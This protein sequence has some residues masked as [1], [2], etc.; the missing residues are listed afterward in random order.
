[1]AYDVRKVAVK[2]SD[3]VIV[4]PNVVHGWA[5]IP[6][7]VDYLSFRPSQSVMQAGWVN[8]TIAKLSTL[9]VHHARTE[10]RGASRR[11]RKLLSRGVVAASA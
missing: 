3:V 10:S 7:H 11:A 1:M 8:P 4:P 6:D 9:C 2:V 5:D